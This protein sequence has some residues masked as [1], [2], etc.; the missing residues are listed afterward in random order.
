MLYFCFVKRKT[1]TYL[2]LVLLLSLVAQS[3]L[4]GFLHI[5]SHHDHHADVHSEYVD[6]H[7]HQGD[8][9]DHDADFLD[10]D[11]C[12]GCDLLIA[13]DKQSLV[14]NSSADYALLTENLYI[15][16][17]LQSQYEGNSLLHVQGR[18]PPRG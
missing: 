16:K 15:E 12:A 14:S 3:G 2:S 18:A 11:D 8:S 6:G 10:A 5:D 7:D 4:Y 13:L 17:T 1:R 9:H